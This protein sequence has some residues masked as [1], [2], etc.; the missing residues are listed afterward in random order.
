MIN[1]ALAAHL[2]PNP[3]EP[4][5]C[6]LGRLTQAFETELHEHRRLAAGFASTC[7]MAGYPLMAQTFVPLTAP[8]DNWVSLTA[9]A[10]G[11]HLAAAA[12]YGC[13]YVSGDS[14]ATWTQA[15]TAET[16]AE[17]QRAW[18]AVVSSADGRN[19][20]ALASYEA[21]FTSADYG[22]TWRA[23]GPTLDWAAVASSADGANLVAAD[24][25][26]GG[27]YTSTNAGLSWLRTSAPSKRWRC[28]SSSADGTRLVAGT[29][30]GSEYGDLPA[31]YA[32]SD[33]G[34]TWS[35]TSAP[36]QPW[37][38]VASSAD[39]TKLVAGVYGGFI[40]VSTD[41]GVSW[42]PADVPSL[43]WSSV[44]SSG[45]GD[46]LFAAAW[47]GQVYISPDAGKTWTSAV[48]P[49]AQWQA[50]ASTFDGSQCF[51]AIWNIWNDGPTGI[52][53]AEALSPVSTTNADGTINPQP[54]PAAPLLEM[55]KDGSNVILSWSASFTGFQLQDA[56]DLA[57]STWN[58]VS[59]QP[60]VAGGREQV[61]LPAES[62]SRFFRLVRR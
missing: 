22:Q 30:Y 41:A 28:I 12:S 8:A 23:T 6:Q 61:V 60:T 11:T 36:R 50:V 17:P 2:I 39:G 37:Q 53:T 31:I 32:S 34:T 13:L 33:S 26:M 19:L 43:R 47:E 9:S 4:V 54:E 49:D 5:L 38:T 25:D 59:A 58:D 48:A 20:A 29:D 57:A 10:N 1:R 14:G 3:F 15:R 56:V 24:Y 18:Q 7:F 55:R 44:S 62:G 16:G 52:Y 27:I 42:A 45:H 35:L 40:Y 21:V 51:A 46:K